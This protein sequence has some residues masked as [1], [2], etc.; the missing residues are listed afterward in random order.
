MTVQIHFEIVNGY[1]ATT[2]AMG[3][4]MKHQGMS[5][6]WVKP[7]RNLNCSCCFL[8]SLCCHS[9]LANPMHRAL[10]HLQFMDCLG[11]A[12]DKWLLFTQP[13]DHESSHRYKTR[14]PVVVLVLFLIWFCLLMMCFHGGTNF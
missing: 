1:Q 14:V 3:N 10:S 5:S 12:L 4:S 8:T 2:A 7:F 9:F 6:V 11:S 13:R